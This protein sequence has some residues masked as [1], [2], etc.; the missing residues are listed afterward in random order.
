M[1]FLKWIL[2]IGGSLI[3]LLVAA[4]IGGYFYVVS[5]PRL[6]LSAKDWE[7]GSPWPATE[8]AAFASA[9]LRTSPSHP[10]RKP[11]FCE[12]VTKEAEAKASR[13]ERLMLAAEFEDS[14]RQMAKVVLAMGTFLMTTDK[15][16]DDTPF[17]ESLKRNCAKLRG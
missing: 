12:C 14:W 17:G 15:S 3:V 6:E 8:R 9:C 11:A 1:K 7:A 4:G 13:T 5:G 16:F 2:I 10:E